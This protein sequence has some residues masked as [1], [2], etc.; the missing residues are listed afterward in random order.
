MQDLLHSPFETITT[1]THS[2]ELAT[3]A[4]ARVNKN[5]NKGQT[6]TVGGI[7]S[8]S[9]LPGKSI[10]DFPFPVEERPYYEDQAPI[11]FTTL[12]TTQQLEREKCSYHSHEGVVHSSIPNSFF[13]LYTV[14]SEQ[15][16][17]YSHWM[18]DSGC[19]DLLQIYFVHGNAAGLPFQAKP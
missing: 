13:G 6:Y 19:T 11:T 17:A 12:F 10:R 2:E 1:P 15:T 4:P 18:I 3:Q 8:D 7:P 5:K 16:F 9:L 14:R